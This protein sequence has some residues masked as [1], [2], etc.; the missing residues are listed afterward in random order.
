[1]TQRTTFIKIFVKQPEQL[2]E[3][4]LLRYN[5]MTTTK[6]GLLYG[7]DHTSIIHWCQKFGVKPRRDNP[8][9]TPDYVEKLSRYEQAIRERKIKQREELST[10]LINTTAQKPKYHDMLQ[11]EDVSNGK[12]YKDYLLE[13]GERKFQRFGIELSQTQKV[14]KLRRIKN[15]V[16]RKRNEP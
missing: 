15:F 11:D 8:I 10:V 5:G 1:M 14:L 4:L 7:V 16:I 9:N 3:M 13:Q 2:R 6:L 12:S